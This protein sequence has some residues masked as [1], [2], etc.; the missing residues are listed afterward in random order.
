MVR[1]PLFLLALVGACSLSAYGGGGR[2]LAPF[3]SEASPRGLVFTMMNFPQQ[4]GFYGFGCGFADLDGDGDQDVVILGGAAWRIGIFQNQGNGTFVNRTLTSGIPVMG[5]LSAFATADYDG[6]GDMDLFVSRVFEP[7]LLFR[8]QG[9]MTFVDVT[10]ISGLDIKSIRIGKGAC[11]G[12]Y[13]GDGWVD[14][15]VCNYRNSGAGEHAS[16]NYLYRNNGDG[17]FT[18][19]AEA[20]GV[21]SDSPSL[22]AVWTDFDRD[23]D[24]DLYV[25]NDRGTTPGDPGNELF[26]NDG[27]IFT[28]IALA[29]GTNVKIDAMGLACGD[30]NADGL[31]DFYVTNTS[32]PDP[33]PYQEFPLLLSQPE[34]FTFVREELTWGVAHPSAFWGWA[35][36]F[37]DWN[38]DAHLDLYVTN[39][40]AANSLFQNNGA[41]PA[42]DM[43][44][45][46][47]IG[48]P[49]ATA[50]SKFCSAFADID[51]DGDLDILMNPL[52]GP[53]ELY[54]NNEGSKRSFVRLRVIGDGPNTAAIG[55]NADVTANGT[56]QF[57]EIYSG[58]NSYLGQNEQVLHFGLNNAKVVTSAI[59]RW[60]SGGPVRTFS[61]MPVGQT[62]KIYPPAVLGDAD[63]DG[64]FDVADRTAL[65]AAFGPITLGE[66]RFDLDGN[67]VL[68]GADMQLFK[69]KFV[70]AGFRWVDLNNDGAVNGADLA[71]LLG[72][73]GTADGLA[74]LDGS[75]LVNASDL[76]LLLG[77]WG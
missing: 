5:N 28:D 6:D 74:D 42:I 62:W 47:A 43:A 36:F 65:I 66:E 59:V 3:T 29:C 17:T 12:D 49:V 70:A 63:G 52:T 57:Q 69:V 77:D 7:S 35:A 67:F 15:Y 68:D 60:P 76:A 19:V 46:A 71:I 33:V 18:D 14:L 37:F 24:L 48:G 27:G 4:T 40:Q 23:G 21:N 58:G 8:N 61:N 22:E 13:N 64:D 9:N 16:D 50:R 30:F 56:T 34:P 45:K 41:P 55:A 10:E 1:R 44:A 11:W 38:N 53:A 51:G 20:V 32:G 73:W 39:Q 75:G 26:R 72:A 2:G 31:V 54:I 25:C